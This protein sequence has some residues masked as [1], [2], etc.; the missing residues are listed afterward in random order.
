M[1]NCTKL[2]KGGKI[3]LSLLMI[4]SLLFANISNVV[5]AEGSIGSNIIQVDEFSIIEY[6]SSE[7]TSDIMQWSKT[8]RIP[9]NETTEENDKSATDA[10]SIQSIP[11][12]AEITVGASNSSSDIIVI[13]QLS[14]VITPA[15]SFSA[16]LGV[17][18]YLGTGTSSNSVYG[19]TFYN[20]QWTYTIPM[21]NTIEEDIRL[22]NGQLVKDFQTYEIPTLQVVRYNQVGGSYGS[23]TSA[24]NGHRHHCFSDWVYSQTTVNRY[25]SYGNV[26]GTVSASYSAPVVLLT[27]EDHY[28]TA[29]YGSTP[30]ATAYRNTQLS[31]V[32][33]GKYLEAMQMDINNIRSNFGDRY[34]IAIDEMWNYAIFEL[35]WYQ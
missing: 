27:P 23:I 26:I 22:M 19:S 13:V 10:A 7:I 8:F 33:Q 35:G 29:S 6:D 16:I 31:L 11:S 9:L 25:D 14:G 18:N 24:M 21:T 30:A 15:S 3:L 4:L 2:K 1:S 17:Y 20:K 5:Y 34:N 28:L 32:Q 12:W